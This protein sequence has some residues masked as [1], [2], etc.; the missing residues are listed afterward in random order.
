MIKEA[1]GIGET[2]EIAKE[3]A[4]RELGVETHE[5]EYEILQMPEKKKF[6]LFGGSPAKVRAFVEITPSKVAQDYLRKVLDEMELRDVEFTAEEIENGLNITLLGE[7]S[8]Y[9]IGK[10]GE[11]LDSLQYLTG[12]VANNVDEGY[13]RISI[14]IGNYRQKREKT[15]EVL[16]KKLAFKV[17]KTGKNVEL[18][19]MNP[20]ERR[21][22]H[23]AV[24]KV[25][26]AMSW[27]EGESI[28]R[29]IVIGLDPNA[30]PAYH[31][32]NRYNKNKN[33]YGKSRYGNK[34]GYNKSNGSYNKPYSK[35]YSRNNNYSNDFN[36]QSRE[37]IKEAPTASLYGRVDKK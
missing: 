8:G 11:T 26:G 9:I 12:L 16:G 7:E 18:E 28:D 21:I 32:E 13:Y 15:L 30:K 27:S 34:G 25:K 24:Q 3:N 29:H 22:I 10:R 17:I 37:A 36:N 6:G 35:S 19:P 31:K 23:T 1:I 2:V 4:C 14:N 5:V 20:Y 33:G